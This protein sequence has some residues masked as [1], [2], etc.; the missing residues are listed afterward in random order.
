M[1]ELIAA[2]VAA[3]LDLLLQ[4]ASRPPTAETTHLDEEEERWKRAALQAW[5][6]F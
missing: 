3:V 2:I 6:E 5:R 4:R 1:A